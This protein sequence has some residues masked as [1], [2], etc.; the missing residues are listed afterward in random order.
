MILLACAIALALGIVMEGGFN[1]VLS[2]IAQRRIHKVLATMPDAQASIGSVSVG[3][4]T[5]TATVKDVHFAYKAE[6]EKSKDKSVPGSEVHIDKIEIGRVFFFKLLDNEALVHS[7]NIIRPR[8]E[9]WMDEEHPE[10]CVPKFE[11][12]TSLLHLLHPLNRAELMN[13]D[14]EEASFALHSTRTALDVAVNDF[15]LSMQELTYD[16]VFH[17]CDSI[18]LLSVGSAAVCLPDGRTRIQTHDIRLKEFGYL[19]VGKTKF[20]H[21]NDRMKVNGT[22]SAVKGDRLALNLTNRHID[23]R[24]LQ[25]Q[26]ASMTLHSLVD[27]LEVAANG[28]SL[29]LNKI[30]VNGEGLTAKGERIFR[31]DSAFR[32]SLDSASVRFPDGKMHLT[33]RDIVHK[34][35]EGLSIG[36]TRFTYSTRP[37]ADIQAEEVHIGPLNYAMLLEKEGLM[38][39]VH[40]VRPSVELW[41]D[42]DHPA[43]CFPE[44]K[45]ESR[46]E[47]KE[48]LKATGKKLYAK[49]IFLDVA[50]L[51]HVIVEDAS[52]ALHGLKTH[53]DV[54]ADHCSAAVHALRYDGAFCISDSV[55]SLSLGHAAILTPDS[56]I[57]IEMHDLAHANQGPLTIG[58]TRVRHTVGRMQLGDIVQEPTT[59]IDM[60]M[61]RLSTSPFNP[62]RKA[63]A[64]DYSLD[65]MDVVFGKMDL[66]RDLRYKP[67]K[68]FIMVQQAFKDIQTRFLIDHVDALIKHIHIDL[69]STDINCGQL[70][71]HN[72]QAT[73]DHVTNYRF[74]KT[75]LKGHCAIGSGKM[76]IAMDFT[77][78]KNC[79]FETRLHAENVDGAFLNPLLRPLVGMTCA[80]QIDTLD[81]RYAGSKVRADGTFRMLYHGLQ[82]KVHKED[83]IP[84]K[85]VTRHA[86]AINVAANTLLPKSNPTKPNH[87]PKAYN[88]AW[89]RNEWAPTE[90]YL[91]GPC[92]DGVVKTLLP[93][94][95]I[96]DKNKTVEWN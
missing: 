80:M 4:L 24:R 13:L 31:C 39:T 57:H 92:I 82:A 42:E 90:L 78:N 30:K 75:H 73:A 76:D 61:E 40:V 83:D 23:L 3:L 35:G 41:M 45:V 2:R 10:L 48:R 89:K 53:L 91:F 18:C 81:T 68:P 58:D 36:K 88:I 7:V 93:G 26:N 6:S 5:G 17:I 69:T 72:I 71:M 67:K 77:A 38:G 14:I 52:F 63:F 29:T 95:F 37:G 60:Q 33:T 54:A 15:S 47:K 85:I 22:C 79:D 28:C 96:K 84:Y 19:S 51:E 25:V 64:K 74:D 87:K 49:G 12:D 34:D 32:F 27:S 55:Y 59:W 56:L 46:K 94:L 1:A 9:L 43:S 11:I 16:S 21:T 70:D 44:V 66:V 50:E 20:A 65:K 62:I 8:V 86:G